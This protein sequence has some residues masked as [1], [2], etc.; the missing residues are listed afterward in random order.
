MLLR[1]RMSC[2]LGCGLVLVGCT[3]S[4]NLD[5]QLVSAIQQG[6]LKE[7]T[8]L[9]SRGAEVNKQQGR[10]TPLCIAAMYQQTEISRELISAGAL[11]DPQGVQFAP[12][13]LAAFSG[14]TELI[15]LFL[16]NGANVNSTQAEYGSTP[17]QM[18]A[19]TNQLAAVLVLLE[20]G[21]NINQQDNS[22]ST[23]FDV[24]KQHGFNDLANFLK[25]RAKKGPD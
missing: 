25:E 3:P 4:P 9:I 21:A 17:L 8:M 7:V 10:L 5:Q 23:A 6:N 13:H 2:L 12:L 22:G 24:A 15:G 1:I 14:N 16:D 20:A 18:A 19:S 11:V